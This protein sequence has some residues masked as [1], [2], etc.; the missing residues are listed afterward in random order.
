M[1]NTHAEAFGSEIAAQRRRELELAAW[2]ARV[3]RILAYA[4]KQERRTPR[5]AQPQ[6]RV[7][8]GPQ[9]S[10]DIG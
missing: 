9:C 1:Y 6:P 10:A 2:H 4:R 5:P 7:A 3:V 8:P